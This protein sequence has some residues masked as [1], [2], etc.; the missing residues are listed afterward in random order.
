MRSHCIVFGLKTISNCALHDGP[1]LRNYLV[2][3]QFSVASDNMRLTFAADPLPRSIEFGVVEVFDFGCCK[4]AAK[5]GHALLPIRF[6]DY[7]QSFD[8]IEVFQIELDVLPE[9][10]GFRLSNRGSRVARARS[11]SCQIP[12]YELPLPEQIADM[13]ICRASP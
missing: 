13:P 5:H 6:T 1:G 2:G 10:T 9:G 12:E 4:W 11:E 3:W 7:R 8:V